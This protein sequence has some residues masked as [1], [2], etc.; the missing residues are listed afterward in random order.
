MLC[1]KVQLQSGRSKELF[2]NIRS[3]Q[4][5]KLVCGT[6]EMAKQQ[7]PTAEG[8]GLSWDEKTYLGILS[9]QLYLLLAKH[10]QRF[11]V[12]MQEQEW[13]WNEV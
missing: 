3:L 6:P 2:C 8:W 13:L 7:M 4:Y 5:I 1:Y 12:W 9:G 10:E 11:I